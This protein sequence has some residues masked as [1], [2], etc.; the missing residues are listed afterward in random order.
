[1]SRD[2]SKQTQSATLHI[3]S[4]GLH[5]RLPQCA[6]NTPYRR[7]FVFCML[8][9]V[10][11]APA[12]HGMPFALCAYVAKATNLHRMENYTVLP[13]LPKI[14]LEVHGGYD[15]RKNAFFVDLA[16][17]SHCRT[18]EDRNPTQI[19]AFSAWKIKRFLPTFSPVQWNAEG[20]SFLTWADKTES[21]DR[22]ALMEC[23]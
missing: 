12:A 14:S 23:Q 2:K 16:H 8:F 7:A 10:I 6:H 11:S 15:G 18:A 9:A 3:C 20:N 19:F 4:F 1:M 13:R 5:N 22:A 17:I 21:N